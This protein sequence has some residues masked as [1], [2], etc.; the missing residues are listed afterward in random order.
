MISNVQI[1]AV[2]GDK[3]DMKHNA[4]TDA[5]TEAADTAEITALASAVKAEMQGLNTAYEKFTLELVRPTPLAIEAAKL[6]LRATAE[7]LGTVKEALGAAAHHVHEVK[8]AGGAWK[9]PT[10][11]AD[12][13]GREKKSRKAPN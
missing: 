2:L 1:R 3:I 11:L 5:G 7:L 13:A 9:L 8:N 6:V 4:E 12:R 10:D